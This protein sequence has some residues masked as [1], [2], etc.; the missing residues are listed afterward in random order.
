MRR[1]NEGTFPYCLAMCSMRTSIL[2]SF[3]FIERC[4][5]STNRQN[6]K[7]KEIKTRKHSK[8]DTSNG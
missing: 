5:S 7:G 3:N 4:K 8:T 1:N 6:T 2:S